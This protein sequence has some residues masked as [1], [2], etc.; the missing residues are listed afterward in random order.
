MKK[1]LSILLTALLLI[2]ML[3]FSGCTKSSNEDVEYILKKNTLVV[4]VID[5]P[6]QIGRAHV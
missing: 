4:G 3:A 1:Y 6:P 5:A 2:S